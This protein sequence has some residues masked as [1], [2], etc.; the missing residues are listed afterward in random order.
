MKWTRLLKADWILEEDDYKLN[1][2]KLP[3]NEATADTFIDFINKET[4]VG[5]DKGDV[6]LNPSSCDF[7]DGFIIINNAL[8]HSSW[9]AISDGEY[10]PEDVA[11]EILETSIDSVGVL[12]TLDI[13]D[14]NI[15][16]TK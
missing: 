2:I 10:S 6:Y 12:D 4:V 11:T 13:Y 1:P 9:E 7:E 14:K 16:N 8:L 5:G 3:Y 15:H